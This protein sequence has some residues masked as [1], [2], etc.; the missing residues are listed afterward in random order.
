MFKLE[1]IAVKTLGAPLRRVFCAGVRSHFAST[2]RKLTPIILLLIA[3][4]LAA[5]SPPDASNQPSAAAMREKT[6]ESCGTCHEARIIVQQRLGKAAW[7]KEVD[8]MIKWGAQV[9]PKDRDALIDYLTANYG[10]DQPPYQASR[11]AAEPASP[12]KTKK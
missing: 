6:S 10:P 11:A 8:K 9:D 3:A 5:Q 4:A 2:P 7:T 12:P 1:R